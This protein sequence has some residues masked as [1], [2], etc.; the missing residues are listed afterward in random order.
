MRRC[1]LLFLALGMIASATPASAQASLD[2]AA[3]AWAD[4]DRNGAYRLVVDQLRRAPRDTA[5]LA[6]R[7]DLEIAGAPGGLPFLQQRR[8]RKTAR[9]LL[10]IDSMHVRANA[11]LGRAALNDVLLFQDAIKLGHVGSGGRDELPEDVAALFPDEPDPRFAGRFDL[12]IALRQT[13]W[14]DASGHADAALPNAERHLRRAITTRPDDA[15][16][17]SLLATLLI[18]TERFDELADLAD[19]S[20]EARPES[21]EAWMLVGLAAHRQGRSRESEAAFEEA[22]TRMH[23]SERA[24][25]ED[26][27]RLVPPDTPTDPEA[28]WAEHDTRLLTSISER[29]LEHLSRVVS[30]DLLF[31]FGDQPGAETPRGQIYVRYGPPPL[32]RLVSLGPFA[33]PIYPGDSEDARYDVWQYEDFHYTFSDFYL[34]GR[35]TLYSPSASAYAFGGRMAQQAVADDAIQADRRLRIENPQAA[36]PQPGALPLE[37]QVSSFRGADGESEAV[38]VI[39]GEAPPPEGRRGVFLLLD[40]DSIARN[41]GEARPT[42]TEGGWV[43][44]A[45]VRS[46]PGAYTLAIEVEDEEAYG[47]VRQRVTVRPIRTTG[48][49]VSDLLLASSIEEDGSGA[50]LQRRGHTIVPLTSSTF[51]VGA[52]LYVY[53]EVYELALRDGR[54]DASVET[55]LVPEDRRPALRK[56]WD[57][58]TRRRGRTSYRVSTDIAGDTGDEAIPLFIDTTGQPAGRYT[59][60]LR[61]RDRVAN[62]TVVAERQIELRDGSGE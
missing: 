20:L 6:L 43:E 48:F 54:S 18:A 26:I 53:A 37:G 28:F 56:V 31:A 45:T 17:V 1:G 50:P 60:E 2:A 40:E 47:V 15:E 27:S 59:L 41:V 3:L 11:V 12:R 42:S 16:S 19:A 44:A 34:G 21:P 55:V 9:T 49:E 58:L 38:I 61:I 24:R 7:L 25:V 33:P 51:E 39:T 32:R 23:P 10:A 62:R 46:L 36:S 8:L 13:A 5:A 29:R 30:A 52:P 35:Y 14:I 4:G 57:S 22:L